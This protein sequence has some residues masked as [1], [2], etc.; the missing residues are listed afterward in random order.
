MQKT[1]GLWIE[2]FALVHNAAVVPNNQ[3]TSAPFLAPDKALL[4]EVSPKFV[5]QRFRFADS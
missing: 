3:I 1:A 5:E 4:Y 2:R